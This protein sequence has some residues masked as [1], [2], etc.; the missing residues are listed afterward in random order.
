MESNNTGGTTAKSW[1]GFWSGL[2][3][4]FIGFILI[5]FTQ[6]ITIIAT[7]VLES[8]ETGS[9]INRDTINQLFSNGDVIATSFII[10]LPLMVALLVFV[11]KV[12]RKKEFF[13]YLAFNKVQLKTL[14]FWLLAAFTL[15]IIDGFINYLTDQPVSQWVTNAYQSSNNYLLLF[16]GMV[17]FGPITEELLFRGYVFR[18]WTESR[19]GLYAS[20]ILISLLWAGIH[21]QYD[22]YEMSMI[23]TLGLLLCW[24]RVK[25]GSLLTPITIH[26]FW[27]LISLIQTGQ[28]VYN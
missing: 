22:L 6:I 26:I 28:N 9:K 18:A 14:L 27:N 11:V 13:E 25:T 15:L 19:L 3:W 20:I 8:I 21:L 5:F 7:G 1:S 12:R 24:S 4:F 17:I 2:I 23:F 10:L 16:M